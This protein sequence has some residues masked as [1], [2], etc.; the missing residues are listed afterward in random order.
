MTWDPEYADSD[1][2]KDPESD[3]GKTGKG[4]K[5]GNTKGQ[6]HNP[7]G[8]GNGG[9][10]KADHS[11]DFVANT[12]THDKGQRRKGKPPQRGGGPSPNPDRLSYLL[13]QPCPKHGTK[14]EPSTHL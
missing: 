7:V 2:T 6:H 12:N 11:L 1:S 8:H 3:D 10:R 4:K 13:N 14:E 9:K 5:S